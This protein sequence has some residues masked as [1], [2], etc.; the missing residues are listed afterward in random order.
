MRINKDL[1]RFVWVKCVFLPHI[2]I[3]YLQYGYCIPK[4]S[5]F[6]FSKKT[7]SENFK[8]WVSKRKE[9]KCQER[10]EQ[11]I[12]S[13]RDK[14][15]KLCVRKGVRKRLETFIYCLNSE[16]V[17]LGKA[18]NTFMSECKITYTV[19]N[20]FICWSHTHSW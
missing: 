15:T 3:S 2:Q 10:W 6:L 8:I 19:I 9:K 12:E 7:F 5:L 17:S 20:E 4:C 18:L 16:S 1:E 13:L 14:W 11:R